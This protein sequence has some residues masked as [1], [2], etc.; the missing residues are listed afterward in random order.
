MELF[1]NIYNPFRNKYLIISLDNTLEIPI[2]SVITNN[3]KKT[4]NKD[5]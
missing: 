3:F 1:K 2:N 4:D 5:T